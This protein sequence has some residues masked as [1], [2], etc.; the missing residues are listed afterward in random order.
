MKYYDLK[1]R[2]QLLYFDLDCE[3]AASSC[4]QWN[5]KT[6]TSA[7][8]TGKLKAEDVYVLW[9]NTPTL[10]YLG[11][12]EELSE[13]ALNTFRYIRDYGRQVLR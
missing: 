5:C 7:I 10:W 12:C 6:N 13:R 11:Y 2:K 9:L 1:D 4:P 3:A 8:K